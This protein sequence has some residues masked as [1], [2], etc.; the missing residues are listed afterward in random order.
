MPALADCNLAV[1]EG[2]LWCLCS[3]AIHLTDK[4]GEERTAVTCMQ[5]SIQADRVAIL[6]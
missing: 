2:W 5:E 4:V 3:G 1:G 6:H